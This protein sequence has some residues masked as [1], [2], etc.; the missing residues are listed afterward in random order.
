MPHATRSS[1]VLLAV[2]VACTPTPEAASEPAKTAPVAASPATKPTPPV[3]SEPAAP[4]A[5]A[6]PTVPAQAAPLRVV[7]VREGPV[8]LLR[9]RD[10]PVVT[11][12]GEPV[13][14]V[15]GAFSRSP[16][17]GAGL[18]PGVP[19]GVAKSRT[20]AFAEGLDATQGAWISTMQELER[21]AEVYAVHHRT[22]DQWQAVDL[23][24]G[25]LVAYY[26]AF[27]ERDGAL[28]ALQR[29]AMDP[30]RELD[31]NTEEEE[32]AARALRAKVAR[33]LDDAVHGW[34]PLAGAQV[35]PPEIPAGTRL[36]TAVI[37]GDGTLHAVGHPRLEDGKEGPPSL[38]AW[39][40]GTTTAERVDIPDLD[41]TAEVALAISGE[42]T[43]IHGHIEHE[44]HHEGYLA[45]GRG[46]EWQRVAVRLP[47]R[48]ADAS[49]TVLGAARAPDGALWIAVGNHWIDDG[50]GDAGDGGLRPLWRKPA[51]GEWQPVPLPAV[52]DDVFGPKKTWVRDPYDE[53]VGWT[54][55]ERDTVDTASASAGGLV[56]AAGAVWATLD[57]GSAYLG[58]PVSETP[59]RAL[60]VTTSPGSAPP[61]V[62]PPVWEIQLERQ[63]PG[64]PADEPGRGRCRWYW[65]VLGPAALATTE[66][67]AIAAIQ[68]LEPLDDGEAIVEM[69]YTAELDGAQVLVASARATSPKRASALREAVAKA[70]GLTPSPECRVP[71]IVGR[72]GAP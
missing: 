35:P 41:R 51:D 65:F 21:T 53:A 33:A 3:A 20:L 44:D 1:L 45:V 24:E 57:I 71:R 55:I 40:P 32:P 68:A 39:L 67:A 14:L 15:D 56:W 50:E 29:W 8:G 62:L 23:R 59:Q 52:S 66:P 11:L 38:L 22:G 12:E 19:A 48:A 9:H 54:E 46:R 4:T 43:L 26:S 36:H 72:A 42:H 28:W 10:A 70:S 47:G 27:V 30:A 69:I 63:Y 34:V 18:L 17:A 37:A 13:P 7:A 2:A 61:S 6:A 31:E 49:L 64:A 5:T 16:N 25:V 58:N 60:V